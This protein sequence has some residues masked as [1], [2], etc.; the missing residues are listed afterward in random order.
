FSGRV[1]W[2]WSRA[3]LRLGVLGHPVEFDQRS[4]QALHRLE[5]HHVRSVGRRRI[6]V[7]VGLDEDAGD[8]D[9]YRGAAE[10]R[11]ELALA[12]RRGALPARLLYRMRGAEDN[13]P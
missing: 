12:A 4:K 13:R 11:H 1:E 3:T 9:R 10:H 8:A 7:L 2:R 5:R 6:G